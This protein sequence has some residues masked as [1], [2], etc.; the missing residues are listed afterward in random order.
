MARTSRWTRRRGED[1]PFT[2]GDF[3]KIAQKQILNA[4]FETLAETKMDWELVAPFLD[5]AREVCRGDFE[6]TAQIR[7]HTVRAEGE[8]WVEA[9]EAFLGI[10]VADRDDG[11]EWL[12][13]THWIS[14]I[15]T[16]DEDPEQVARDR[17]GARAQH[18]QDQRLARRQA[19]RR[20]RSGASREKS[21]RKS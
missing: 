1:G 20:R 18:R 17:R 16:A 21:R 9:E 2:S 8:D 4:V 14:D 6:E 15:A 13:E 3:H 5:A 10:S 19:G 7:L 11:K 12:S